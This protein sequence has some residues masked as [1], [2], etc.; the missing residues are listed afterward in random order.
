[1]VAE[2]HPVFVFAAIFG[3]IV[4]ILFVGFVFFAFLDVVFSEENEDSPISDIN[5]PLSSDE[6]QKIE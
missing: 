5:S 6:R 3:A 2:I 1:M 4:A